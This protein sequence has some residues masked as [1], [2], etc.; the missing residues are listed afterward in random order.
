MPTSCRLNIALSPKG[1]RFFSKINSASDC[2]K[3]SRNVK[4]AVQF[5]CPWCSCVIEIFW[6]KKGHAEDIYQLLNEG[7][8]GLNISSNKSRRNKIMFDNTLAS[9]LIFSKR[10]VSPM[11]Q[12]SILE[13]RPRIH[14]HRYTKRWKHCMQANQHT[15]GIK[16]TH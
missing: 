5:R 13:T 4:I 12:T 11:L 16:K 2:D 10:N 9:F 7:N 6:S 14:T 1:C 8:S 3:I 15:L